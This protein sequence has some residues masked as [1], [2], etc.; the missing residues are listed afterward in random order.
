MRIA[1]DTKAG[2]EL[3]MKFGFG[4][5]LVVGYPVVGNASVLFMV[6]VQIGITTTALDVGAFM[7]FKGS[8]EI[9]GGLVSVCIQIE[10]QGI[11]H[12]DFSGP[13]NCIAQV[14]FSI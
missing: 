4:I 14:D 3:F 9:L 1:A 6:G 12:R 11:V 13:C 8:A 2:L 7:L 5:E 10:A